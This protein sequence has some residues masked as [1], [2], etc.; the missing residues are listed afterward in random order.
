MKLHHP[1]SCQ[2]LFLCMCTLVHKAVLMFIEHNN[3]R[4]SCCIK[5]SARWA[6]LLVRLYLFRTAFSDHAADP[7]D[8]AE[9]LNSLKRRISDAG[10]R[11]EAHGAVALLHNMLCLDSETTAGLWTWTNNY[12]IKPCSCTR[13]VFLFSSLSYF[14][15]LIRFVILF[16]SLRNLL[17]CTIGFLFGRAC[18]H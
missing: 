13:S 17:T 1:V 15:V 11:K 3:P 9:M 16:C 18:N 4:V 5:A 10:V 12:K 2:L 6:H 14:L 7:H 8:P